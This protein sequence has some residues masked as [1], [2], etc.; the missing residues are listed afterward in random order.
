MYGLFGRASVRGLPT[1]QVAQGLA[2]GV[3]LLID[4][5]EDGATARERIAGAVLVPLSRRDP[6]DLPE[7]RGR[8]VVFV[9]ASGVRSAKAARHRPGGG[10]SLRGP[11]RRRPRRL[12]G[13]GVPLET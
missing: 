3:I 5:R 6:R 4:V 2:A 11:P 12:E 10:P 9:C 1:E 8:E 13:A 7:P